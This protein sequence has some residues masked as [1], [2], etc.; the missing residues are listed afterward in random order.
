M[1]TVYTKPGCGPCKA[2]IRHMTRHGIP[3]TVVDITKDKLAEATILGLG[4]VSAPV[5]VFD[6]YTHWSGFRDDLIDTY[7]PRS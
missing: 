7:K 6:E 1:L 3:H 5:V 2:T 4:Y